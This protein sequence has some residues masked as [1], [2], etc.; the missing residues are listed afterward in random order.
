MHRV[1]R[2]NIWDLDNLQIED[3]RMSSW[4]LLLLAS[5][6]LERTMASTFSV[7]CMVFWALIMALW[8]LLF[9]VWAFL[10]PC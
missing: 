8:S 3:G 5:A 6:H 7:A 4:N 2:E 1:A 9:F 10:F